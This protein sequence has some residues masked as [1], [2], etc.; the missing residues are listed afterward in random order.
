MERRRCE[1]S[2]ERKEE[3]RSEKG[4]SQKTEDSGAR[5][6]KTSLWREARFQVKIIKHTPH[7][8]HFWTCWCRFS[9]ARAMD[10]A[11]CPKRATVV[12]LAA[13]P[14]TPARGE[15]GG[16]ELNVQDTSHSG[17]GTV[18]DEARHYRDCS[19]R[20]F[21]V[22]L[23]RGEDLHTRTLHE[24]PGGTFMQAP[25]QR[26]FKISMPRPLGEGF[27]RIST[28]SSCKDLDQVM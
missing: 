3:N 15:C 1:E 7:S 11:P 9:V 13:L 12:G 20:T 22:D 17:Y 16:Q 14:N 18:T 19:S 27:N 6:G 28:R 24:H 23:S 8:D 21:Y 25:T 10:S 4:K 26:I 2:K 5:K